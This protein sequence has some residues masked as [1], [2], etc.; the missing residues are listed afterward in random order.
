MLWNILVINGRVNP[1]VTNTSKNHD[2]KFVFK[3]AKKLKIFR[4]KSA[5]CKIIRQAHIGRIN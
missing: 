4:K 3:K 5:E 2:T 1:S